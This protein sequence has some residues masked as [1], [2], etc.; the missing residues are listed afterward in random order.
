MI[1]QQL[2]KAMGTFK[3][4]FGNKMSWPDPN[5]SDDIVVNMDGG[6]G[7]SWTVKDDA[8]T[9]TNDAKRHYADYIG[10]PAPVLTPNDPWFNEPVKTEKM[11]THEEM[12]EIAHEREKDDKPPT[13][14]PE[15]IH[16]VMYQ[17]AT[18][19][20]NTTVQLDPP[21]GSENFHEGPGGWTSGTGINQ[22]R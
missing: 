8:E 13:K 5:K 7:G 16:E 1:K 2:K 11:L 18:K 20:Q 6:V 15:N 22:F 3:D 4:I 14:E 19:N 12:L 9:F 10:V 17:K 21:G